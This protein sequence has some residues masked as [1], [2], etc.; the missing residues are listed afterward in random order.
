V[1]KARAPSG[2]IRILSTHQDFRR[3]YLAM[4]SAT[5]ESLPGEVLGRFACAL[6]E[7]SVVRAGTL[8]ATDV[9][10]TS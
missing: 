10:A 5:Q 8:R 3:A 9:P 4:T 1:T 2:G 7:A 6:L